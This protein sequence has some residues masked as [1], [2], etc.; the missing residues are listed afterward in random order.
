VRPL[1]PSARFVK[2]HFFRFFIVC[3]LLGPALFLALDLAVAPPKSPPEWR[4]WLE[5][6]K[7]ASIPV[8]SVCFTWW[9]VWLGIQMCWYP[10][11]FWGR[12]PCLGWQGIV[13][14]RARIMAERSCDLM[15]GNLVTIEE[16][17]DRI[18]PED[19]FGQLGP[20]LG[21]CSTAVL[22]RLAEKHCPQVWAQLPDSV[23]Q[24]LNAKVM[25][26]SVLM[27]RP[28][29]EDLKQNVTKIFD[30]KQ[31]AVEALIEDKA[32]LVSMFQ[33]ISQ[34]EFTFVLRVAAVMGFILG[35]VQMGVWRY[36]HVWWSLPV[37]GLVIGYFTNW[38]AITMI[39]RPVQPHIVCCGYVNCQGVF[40]KR[41]QE[42]SRELATMISTK[43][44]HAE[45]ILSYVVKSEGFQ[46]VLD[47]YQT[48]MDHAVDQVLGR[49]SRVLPAFVGRDAVRG[50]KEE[51]AQFTLE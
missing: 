13:P 43:L 32:L 33:D 16:L 21:T 27:F 50:I 3:V 48:H 9:H 14:R 20:T 15:I 8:V 12:P 37:T 6:L 29:I 24:E 46:Q 34:K 18:H 45:R 17:V 49:T 1:P 7:Y 22:K 28:V 31:M 44:I 2:Q 10:I 25:E 30:I 38:L 5:K 42:V 35:L 51:V 4:R 41:Q 19:F 26:Q 47:I 36:I 39:F 23:R 11:E 40:L